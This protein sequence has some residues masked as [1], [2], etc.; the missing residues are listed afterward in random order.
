LRSL[1]RADLF[2]PALKTFTE[3]LSHPAFPADQF[4]LT[5]AQTLQAIRAEQQSPGAIISRLFYSTLY[6]NQPYAHASIGTQK[7]V[8][9]ITQKNVLTFYNRY[10]TAKNMIIVLVGNLDRKQAEKIAN[11]LTQNIPS[12][13]H[14]PQLPLSEALHQALQ[15]HQAFPSTQTHIMIGSL[16]INRKDPYYFSLL[17]GNEILGGGPLTSRLFKEI[18]DTRGL[19]YSAY[20]GFSRLREKGPF[21]IGIQT[22]NEQAKTAIQVAKKTLDQFIQKGPSEQELISAKRSI[23]G[24]FPLGLASNSAIVANL[25]SIAF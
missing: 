4:K 14:A 7:T 1:T 24:S 15:K 13:S 9:T 2:N 17:V 12:G 20:S 6:G 3:I 25:S 16:G 11:Q 5:T 18:R 10:Y 22:R 8:P 21:I 19:A 23:I